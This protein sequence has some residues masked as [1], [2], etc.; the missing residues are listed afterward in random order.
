[1]NH[2][3]LH[4][5]ASYCNSINLSRA[6]ILWVLYFLLEHCWLDKSTWWL[7]PLP[8]F[9]WTGSFSPTQDPNLQA[10][11]GQVQT[12]FHWS[13]SVHCLCVGTFNTL[14]CWTL[15]TLLYMLEIYVQPL[16]IC[17]YSILVH[18]LYHFRLSLHLL[19]I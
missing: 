9:F 2:I 12:H 1:M 10:S 6:L 13:L 15:S 8:D 5:R 14:G 4:K 17:T 16:Y 3:Y 18:R 19:F 7:L 11:L